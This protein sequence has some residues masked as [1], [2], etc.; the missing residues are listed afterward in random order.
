MKSDENQIDGIEKIQMSSLRERVYEEV[1]S[2][3]LTNQIRPGQQ[4]VIDQLGRQFGVS[5][6]PLREAL[7]MLALDGLVT[8]ERHKNAHVT[9]IDE[10]DVHDVYELRTI[11]EGFAA[12]QAALSL[13][14]EKLEELNLLLQKTYKRIAEGYL[15]PDQDTD[16]YL[17]NTIMGVVDNRLFKR[18]AELVTNQSIRIRRLVAAIGFE[19]G[20]AEQKEHTAI[21]E[22]IRSRDPDLARQKMEQHLSLAQ[23]RSLS[24]L[25]EISSIEE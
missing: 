16:I 21:I 24:A 7:A 14:D 25:A 8:M 13:S 10:K 2:R 17:H 5:H 4:I 3:I 23:Q 6:T 11:I 19:Y 1:K 9:R 12:S 18:V 15:E 22:A 20:E